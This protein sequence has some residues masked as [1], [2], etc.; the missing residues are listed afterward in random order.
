MPMD[1]YST[2]R[3]PTDLAQTADKLVGKYGFDSRAD[4]VKDA[5]RRLFENYPE[6]KIV[7]SQEV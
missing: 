1:K 7:C 2:V 6:T 3:I 4:V 5:L